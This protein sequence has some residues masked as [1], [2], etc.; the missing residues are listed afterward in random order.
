M[1]KGEHIPVR[2]VRCLGRNTRELTFDG[3]TS[4]FYSHTVVVI[5][6]DGT[7]YAVD[8]LTKMRDD[9]GQDRAIKRGD[10][11]FFIPNGRPAFKKD[12]NGK[13]Y[14]VYSGK[15]RYKRT[16]GE[17]VT[18]ATHYDF[19]EL[20]ADDS[21]AA[22]NGGGAP[23]S[24]GASP[25]SRKA[26]TPERMEELQDYTRA[27]VARA[28]QGTEPSADAQL[29]AR[30]AC[31]ATLF[32]QDAMGSLDLDSP[33]KLNGHD[34]SVAAEVCDEQPPPPSDEDEIPF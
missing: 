30:Q 26:I 4:N 13:Q 8:V 24:T 23:T 12:Y 27:L 9:E 16:Q 21:P 19:P 34:K 7:E 11:F 2:A 28:C 18:L 31:W 10:T 20:P 14:D 29:A 22:A 15:M 1:E 5:G 25:R 3:Q 6:T 33:A 17:D 32:I